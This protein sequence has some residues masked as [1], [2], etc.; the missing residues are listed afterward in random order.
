MLKNL[1]VIAAAA[2]VAFAAAQLSQA[3]APA[4]AGG[5]AAAGAGGFA[6]AGG[7]GGAGGVASGLSI[8]AQGNSAN[9]WVLDARSNRLTVCTPP[10]AAD[11][12]PLC[13]AW[14]VIE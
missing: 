8:V 1:G 6:G 14:T 10:A 7:R 12:G 9:V 5:G 11:Q 13:A 3:Q 4:P 2:L